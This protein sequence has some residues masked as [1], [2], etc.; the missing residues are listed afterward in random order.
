MVE[1]DPLGL[2]ALRDKKSKITVRD[3]EINSDPRR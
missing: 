2:K 3:S 1:S